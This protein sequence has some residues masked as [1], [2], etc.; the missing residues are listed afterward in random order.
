MEGHVCHHHE[1]VEV[2]CGL[3][4]PGICLGLVV[5]YGAGRQVIALSVLG[6]EYIMALLSKC[7][8][9]VSCHT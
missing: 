8:S 5:G 3:A 1:V 4:Q 6:W 9:N 7:D 2:Y